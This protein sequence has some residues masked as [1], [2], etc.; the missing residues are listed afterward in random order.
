[1]SEVLA[2]FVKI[3]AQMTKSLGFNDSKQGSNTSVILDL[4]KN[5][6]WPIFHITP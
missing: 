6:S 5:L 3:C 4:T 2:E 1:M